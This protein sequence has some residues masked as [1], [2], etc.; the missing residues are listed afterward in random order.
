MSKEHKNVCLVTTVYSFFLY[1]LIKGYNENDI[2]IFTAWFPKEVSKNIPHIQMPPVAF[3]YG[4]KMYSTDSIKGIFQNVLGY[5]RY[6]YGYI[7]LRILFFIKT[8][9]KE[10][11]IYGHAQTPFSYMFYENENSNI[12]EDGLQNYNPNIC[13][14]HKINPIIDKILHLCGIYFLNANEALGSHKNIKTVYLTREFNHPLIKDKVE[15][16]DIEKKWNNL[17]D[18]EQNEILDIF[19]VNVANINFDG[20][21]AL[22][23]SQPLSEDNLATYEDELKIYDEFIDK[24]SDYEI[25][26]KPH[27]RDEKDYTKIYP[28]IKVIDKHFP[29]E[30]LN[31]ININPTVVCSAISTALLNFKNSEIYIYQGELKNERLK[32]LREEL[33]KLINEKN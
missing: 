32:K 9:N 33:I 1:L 15:V 24:F 6:F 3:R 7:K 2:F 21:T 11:D 16:I 5:C 8:C 14:T 31:L 29:I 12:I 18:N 26:I 4:A 25:I 27:P 23:L 30:L 28:N 10:I 20:K 13:E 22:I 19:N 17:T